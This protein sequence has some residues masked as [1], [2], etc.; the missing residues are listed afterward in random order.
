M[1]EILGCSDSLDLLKNHETRMRMP[2]ASLEELFVSRHCI[3]CLPMTL[4]IF[5][6]RQLPKAPPPV[7]VLLLR[8]NDT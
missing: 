6:V 4:G 8:I 1:E 2:L 3:T 7:N 5:K